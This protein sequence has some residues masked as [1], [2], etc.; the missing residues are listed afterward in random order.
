MSRLLQTI[1]VQ[2]QVCAGMGSSMSKPTVCSRR[3]W[4]DTKTIPAAWLCR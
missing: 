1:Q 2:G 4:P 3:S